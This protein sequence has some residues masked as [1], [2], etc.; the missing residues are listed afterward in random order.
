MQLQFESLGL[1]NLQLE[2]CVDGQELLKRVTEIL[3][4]I[5]PKTISEKDIQPL[6][7]IL[8]DI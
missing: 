7:L 3:N 5:D 1:E 6:K 2:T 8:C 4:G